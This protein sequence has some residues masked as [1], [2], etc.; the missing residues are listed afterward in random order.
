MK[1]IAT[2]ENEICE[3]VIYKDQKVWSNGLELYYSG[4]CLIQ[5]FAKTVKTLVVGGSK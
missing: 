5:L 2:C 1:S 3:K 4:C